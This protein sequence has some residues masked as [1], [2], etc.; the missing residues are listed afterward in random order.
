MKQKITSTFLILSVFIIV[1]IVYT[2]YGL[3]I[4]SSIS[5]KIYF[6][7]SSILFFLVLSNLT[8]KILF[9]FN[10]NYLKAVAYIGIILF[11]SMF[12][13]GRF[14][15][16]SKYFLYSVN[17]PKRPT[18]NL[19]QTDKKFAYK[20]VPLS[21]GYYEYYLSDSVSGKVEIQ[22]DSL[23]Y[24]SVKASNIINA[25]TLNLF[26]GCSWTFGDYIQAEE[27]Y[28]YKLSKQL[29]HNFLNAGASGYGLAQMI[30]LS[31]SLLSKHSFKY[32]FIQYSPWLADRA[33]SLNVPRPYVSRP[34][35]YFSENNGEFFLE[36]IP[37]EVDKNERDWRLKN[38]YIHKLKFYFTTGFKEQFLNYSKSRI[39]RVKSE[40]GLIKKPTEN[41]NQLEFFFYKHI[42]ENCKKF[43][44]T[45]IVLKVG[46]PKSG[47][48]NPKLFEFLNEK[49]VKVI[50]LDLALK[51][52]TTDLTNKNR[53]LI[54]HEFSSGDRVYY[55]GHP[56]ALA[57]S[58]FSNSI[59]NSLNK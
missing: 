24:R 6:V 45:P 29:N 52:D 39:S 17:I 49:D 12:V 51:N 46:L 15:A 53:Y 42:I 50:D 10:K 59:F 54:Y 14:V 32:C 57:N 31:D 34:F 47:S 13:S 38:K 5:D 56:N 36:E 11:V 21:K 43:N 2:L 41:K 1:D 8:Y 40:L 18:N 30:Q 20:A 27:G 44:V 26:L 16:M 4:D 7:I 33:M 9:D 22:F 23:G 37:Y 3:K 25:D 35:P 58:I 48:Y 28:A 55:D 19:W